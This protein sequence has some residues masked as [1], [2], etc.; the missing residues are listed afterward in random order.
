[1]SHKRV[2]KIVTHKD[3]WQTPI[4]LWEI[5]RQE[6]DLVVDAA[7]TP[8]NALTSFSMGEDSLA[9]PWVEIFGKVGF[10]LNPPFS[11]G[12]IDRFMAKALEESKKGAVVV[13]LVPCATDTAWWHNYVMKAQEIR[14]IRGWV[15]FVGYDEQGKQI[16]NSPTFSSC[17]VI[18][19]W[20]AGIIGNPVIGKIIE[21]P[22]KVPV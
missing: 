3:E 6:Y 10:F 18:F 19:D 2:T 17:V 16:K 13:C 4:W 20:K 14:F 7:C 11:A 1:M 12:N 15:R 22:R 21:Q 9:I 8:E 5:L